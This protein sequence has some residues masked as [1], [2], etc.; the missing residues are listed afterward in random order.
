MAN[1]NTIGRC[2][3]ALPGTAIGA[4]STVETQCT[5][6]DGNLAFAKSRLEYLVGKKFKVRCGGRATTGAA[7]NVTIKLYYGTS[8]TIGSNSVIFSSGAVAVNTTSV[9]W[10]LEADVAF[11]ATALIL[12]GLGKGAVNATA[13][14][15]AA[16]TA[17]SSLTASGECGFTVTATLSASNAGSLTK[18]DY[19]EIEL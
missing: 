17:V 1:A 10:W 8:A 7:T 19:L 2:S 11:D 14:A 16:T 4:S 13:V 6:G 12:Q 5:D 18:L 15:Q 9:N 3:T